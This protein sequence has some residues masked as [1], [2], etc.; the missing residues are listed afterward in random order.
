ML[1]VGLT[2]SIGMGKSTVGGWFKSHGFPVWDA[3][4][5]VHQLY[6]GGA[7]VGPVGA[8]VPTAV[9][10]GRID[11]AALSG[12]LQHDPDL[13]PKLE[14]IVHPLVRLSQFDFLCGAQSKGIGI[15]ILDIPLLFETAADA[16]VDVVVVVHAPTDVQRERVLARP[17]MTTEKFDAIAARQ[18]GSDE[19]CRY[20]D[21]VIETHLS[22]AESQA[23]TDRLARHLTEQQ[24]TAFDRIWATADGAK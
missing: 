4:A 19:K 24:G 9:V 10:D 21:F 7:A 6:D 1:I 22:L 14:E 8:L 3:D 11:R 13:F 12:A 18:M 2:G 15:A 20:A 23:Q 17:G 16:R 5:A